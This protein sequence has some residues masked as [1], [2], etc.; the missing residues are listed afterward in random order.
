METP[1][2]IHIVHA[3][4]SITLSINGLVTISTAENRDQLRPGTFYIE[5]S[6]IDGKQIRLF[7]D[8]TRSEVLR[9]YLFDTT[10]GPRPL[11]RNERET[12]T[13]SCSPTQIQPVR[14]IDVTN[15]S[16]VK[17]ATQRRSSAHP[18]HPHGFPEAQVNA[19]M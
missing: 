18:I 3:N 2:D 6:P 14:E 10:T 7:I 1:P 5:G 15:Q 19:Q 17:A 11:N 12:Y 4:P 13:L 16:A 9:V 8:K